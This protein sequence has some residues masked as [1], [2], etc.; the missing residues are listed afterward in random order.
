MATIKD[1][2]KEAGVGVGT[3]SRALN[4]TGFVSPE[5]K[6]KIDRAVARLGFVP[7]QIARSFKTQCTMAAAMLIPTILHPFFSKII[8]Y[9]EKELSERG[10]RLI[11]VN[12]EDD[13]SKELKMLEMI[14]QSRVDGIIFITHHVHEN[15]DAS[16][17]IVSV[18]RHIG[19][20]VPFVTSDNYDASRRAVEYLFE[21]GAKKV[22]CVCGATP[23]E[24]EVQQRYKAYLD[25]VTERGA[26]PMLMV[27]S[28]HHGEE[29]EVMKE[30][31]SRY[32]DI[33]GLFTGSDMLANA[34]YHNATMAGKN[35][36]RDLQ[37]VGFDGV[38]SEWSPHPQLTT[39]EQDVQQMAREVVDILFRRMRG[40]VFEPRIIIPARLKVGETTR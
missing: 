32:P 27:K 5:S 24:S 37:I 14:R 35:V 36:P 33:D 29:M 13:K 1:V 25:A 21:R 31:M 11:V 30:F 10:Y 9:A 34:A 3:A 26:E 22:G 39:V 40:D 2:A 23:V 8:F 6:A 20:G 16:L 15:I 18:D 12:S 17:P 38:L 4:G 28:F 19:G 7:N